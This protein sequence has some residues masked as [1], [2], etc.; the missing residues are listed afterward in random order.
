MPRERRS[1]TWLRISGRALLAESRGAE[2]L[3]QLYEAAG[4][5]LRSND[6]EPRK[7]MLEAFEALGG[8]DPA[9]IEYRRKLSI[10]L[11]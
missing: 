7:A 9:V 10:L 2:G 5:D 6:S 3:E 11:C 8:A 1:R 4:L